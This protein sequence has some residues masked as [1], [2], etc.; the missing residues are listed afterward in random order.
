MAGAPIVVVAH[1]PGFCAG[2]STTLPQAQAGPLLPLQRKDRQFR[3]CPPRRV[4][5]HQLLCPRH[6]KIPFI[7]P[8]CRLSMHSLIRKQADALV[9]SLFGPLGGRAL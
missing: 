6:A 9:N 2:L 1:Q 3:C 8:F 7:P 5:I 4:F